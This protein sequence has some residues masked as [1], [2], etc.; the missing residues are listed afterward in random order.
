LP[1][2]GSVKLPPRAVQCLFGSPDMMF[3]ELIEMV[4]FQRELYDLAMKNLEQLTKQKEREALA[5]LGK[6]QVEGTKLEE[7]I[8]SATEELEKMRQSNQ[9]LEKEL[10][11]L[12]RKS[13]IPKASYNIPLPERI[14]SPKVYRNQVPQAGGA[15]LMSP[16]E[17]G[18][19]SNPVTPTSSQ[20]VME[21][22]AG[23]FKTPKWKNPQQVFE[24]GAGV[25]TSVRMEK[26][27]DRRFLDARSP[28]D[29]YMLPPAPEDPLL[30]GTNA[31]SQRVASVSRPG[32]PE[33]RAT[34]ADGGF[35]T[36]AQPASDRG[37]GFFTSPSNSAGGGGGINR[38]NITGI[39]GVQALPPS[40]RL[41]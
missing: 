41:R 14:S 35:F 27:G 16:D 19:Y 17:D 29:G 25:A 18:F 30:G 6:V 4:T 8:A 34:A 32:G 24:W 2:D 5:E 9:E 22:I 3:D 28:T 26:Y 21:K 10:E 23:A 39:S 11:E 40:G 12:M 36:P 38:Y 20:N 7:K 15:D 33:G 31:N 13:P 37:G 1:L